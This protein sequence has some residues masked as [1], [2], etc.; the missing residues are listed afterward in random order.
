[1]AQQFFATIVGATQGPFKGQGTGPDADKIPGVAFDYGLTVPFDPATGLAAG[2]RQ[3]KP[4]VFTMEWGAASPQILQAA[5]SNEILKSVLFEFVD[6]DAQGVESVTFTV[7]LANA[8]ISG[9]DGSV[10]IG[11]TGGPVV[12]DRE[13][14]VVEFTFE[15][16]TVTSTAGGTT[17]TDDWVSGQ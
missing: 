4:V 11:Q 8:A 2:K 16:I 3:Y 7:S 5:A 9:F 13:L 15:K 12:D 1:M 17:A 6:V 10:H 14:T